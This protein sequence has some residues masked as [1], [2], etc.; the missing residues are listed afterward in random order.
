MMVI[1]MID[2]SQHNFKQNYLATYDIS[3]FFKFCNSLI[4]VTL[5]RIS[6]KKFIIYI[7]IYNYIYMYVYS[8][9]L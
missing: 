6:I 2:G 3:L 9:E 8:N 1:M 4:E 7:Y 5:K